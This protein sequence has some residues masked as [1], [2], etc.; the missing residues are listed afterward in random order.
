MDSPKELNTPGT[1]NCSV[2]LNIK[3]GTLHM[4]KGN[5]YCNVG[6]LKGRHVASNTLSGFNAKLM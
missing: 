2:V 1:S 5:T 3:L 4:T 6:Y